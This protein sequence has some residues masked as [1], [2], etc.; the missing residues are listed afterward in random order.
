MPIAN[1]SNNTHKNIIEKQSELYIKNGKKPSI[2]EIVEKYI[3]IGIQ[4]EE[5]L[6]NLIKENKQLSNEIEKLRG[7]NVR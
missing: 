5:K 1:I 2:S 6:E 3:N 4:Y 7:C